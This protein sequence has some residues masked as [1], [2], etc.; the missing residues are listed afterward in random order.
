M[1]APIEFCPQ[2]PESGFGSVTGFAA[3]EWGYFSFSEMQATK[4]AGVCAV[5]VDLNFVPRKS[6]LLIGAFKPN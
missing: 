3:D 2:Q 4:F 5:E 6:S 1:S